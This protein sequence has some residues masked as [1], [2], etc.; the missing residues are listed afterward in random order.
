[1]RHGGWVDGGVTALTGLVRGG[2]DPRVVARREDD[3]GGF[4]SGAMPGVDSRPQRRVGLAGD[5]S[6]TS[7]IRS[8]IGAAHK[9]T[10]IS[11]GQGPTVISA[12]LKTPSPS[13]HQEVHDAPP[14]LS[15]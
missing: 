1:M 2:R 7:I 14:S 4:S 5:N 3:G 8:V 12:L 6:I 9:R 15:H 11:L 10:A 13:D